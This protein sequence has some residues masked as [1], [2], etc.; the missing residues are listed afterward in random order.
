MRFQLTIGGGPTNPCNA[1]PY[2]YIKMMDIKGKELS[3]HGTDLNH[4][5]V[6]AFIKAMYDCNKLNLQGWSISTSSRT[7]SLKK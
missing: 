6:Q 2:I 3:G 4:Q 7:D 1:K 5:Y